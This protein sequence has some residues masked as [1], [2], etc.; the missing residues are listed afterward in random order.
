[1]KE[2]NKP[3]H[4][5]LTTTSEVKYVTGCKVLHKKDNSSQWRGPGTVIGQVSQQVFLKHESF[6]IRVHPCKMQLIKPGL[7]TRLPSS[8]T[9]EPDQT[10][11]PTSQKSHPSATP[12]N[13]DY[14]ISS[15]DEA[16][17]DWSQPQTEMPSN[18]NGQHCSQ[19]HHR[20]LQNHLV[21]TSPAESLL[22]PT[23]CKVTPNT[24]VKLKVKMK[25]S[26]NEATVISRAGKATGKYPN[27]WKIK[28]RDGTTKSIN[29][30]KVHSWKCSQ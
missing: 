12:Q 9:N 27:C 20:R 2:S 16:P 18:S 11:N 1:M 13:V 22:S 5:I 23:H 8:Q 4:T 7:R 21:P 19:Q 14:F 29:F 30:D 28:E 15:Q 25:D 6:Y 17:T 3:L 26:W 24:N 10:E